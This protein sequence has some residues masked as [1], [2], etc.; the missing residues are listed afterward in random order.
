[1]H[2]TLSLSA[3][4]LANFIWTGIMSGSLLF[5]SASNSVPGSELALSECIFQP[6]LLVPKAMPISPPG[7][8][9][10]E[11]T[12]FIFSLH[13]DCLPHSSWALCPWLFLSVSCYR[14]QLRVNSQLPARC[15]QPLRSVCSGHREPPMAPSSTSESTPPSKF[16]PS[17]LQ[18]YLATSLFQLPTS[19]GSHSYFHHPIIKP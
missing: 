9:T 6:Q 11:S 13:A 2:V 18:S 10:V 12:A 3:P 19:G 14:K 17:A 1:M 15:D 8:N 7:H 16:L 4:E 5:F